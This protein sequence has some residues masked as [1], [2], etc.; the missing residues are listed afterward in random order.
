MRQLL[1]T[2]LTLLS[3]LVLGQWQPVPV[4][5]QQGAIGTGIMAAPGIGY[6]TGSTYLSPSSGTDSRLYRTVNDWAGSQ[7]IVSSGAGIYCC[8]MDVVGS[9]GENVVF[10]RFNDGGYY[11]LRSARLNGNNVTHV[12]FPGAG[13]FHTL[14]VLSDTMCIVPRWTGHQSRILRVTPHLSEAL[15]TVS[16][17]AQVA[18]LDHDIGAVVSNLND[19]AEVR[20]TI[21]GGEDWMTVLFDT[22]HG[23]ERPEWSPDGT[24]WLVGGG[25][26]VA[27][28]SD[29][30]STWTMNAV[31][32]MPGLLCVAPSSS[33]SA[34]VGAD[35]GVVYS[36]WNGGQTWQSWNSGQTQVD[37]LWAFGDV[38]YAETRWWNGVYLQRGG[39][40]KRSVG[41]GISSP[42]PTPLAWYQVDGGVV[43]SLQ[44]GEQVRSLRMFQPLGNEVRAQVADLRVGMEHLASGP[45]ILQVRTDRRVISGKVFW[46]S[47][48]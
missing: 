20:L 6:W 32:G 24:L 28:T 27:H 14:E 18:F 29:H 41:V 17:Y 34:F 39:L 30:G 40:Y 42:D 9:Y 22:E 1:S 37:N 25:G 38:V 13:Y 21:N 31:P 23:F 46:D 47:Q 5:V 15:D 3:S 4:S 48:H 7:M 45:Y 43:L 8:Y 11:Q 12:H 26:W 35:N 33:E 44:N 2:S 16:G 19:S 10:Y 36:T